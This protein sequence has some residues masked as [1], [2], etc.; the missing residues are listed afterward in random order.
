MDVNGEEQ[1]DGYV[2][3]RWRTSEEGRAEQISIWYDVYIHMYIYNQD[4]AKVWARREQS[5][6]SYDHEHGNR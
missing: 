3:K 5:A 1:H 2:E 4:M 6:W